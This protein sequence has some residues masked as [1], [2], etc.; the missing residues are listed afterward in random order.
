MFS[1]V[2]GQN[3]DS[4]SMRVWDVETEESG[5]I[6]V[7]G[8]GHVDEDVT[9]QHS[10]TPLLHPDMIIHAARYANNRD[11]LISPEL[12]YPDPIVGF[13][14]SSDERVVCVLTRQSVIGIQL[15]IG[16]AG[17]LLMST[18]WVKP[19]I[20][21]CEPVFVNDAFIVCG[22]GQD[23]T[24][25]DACTGKVV[26]ILAYHN[27]PSNI[28]VCAIGAG[29]YLVVYHAYTYINYIFCTCKTFVS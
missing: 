23:S 3:S 21:A 5:S 16:D 2:A 27:L 18:V 17:Q 7:A 19:F 28:S 9:L 13:C 14:L 29:L 10:V 24:A 1:V 6:D 15:R 11:I 12:Y 8:D 22:A 4:F 26:Q 20:G 25:Y